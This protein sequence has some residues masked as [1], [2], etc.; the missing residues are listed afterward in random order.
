MQKTQKQSGRMYSHTSEAEKRTEEVKVRFNLSE[1]KTVQENAARSGKLPS[2][3]CREVALGKEQVE[4]KNI[5]RWGNLGRLG[6]EFLETK[7]M[8]QQRPETLEHLMELLEEAV[9]EI[10]ALRRELT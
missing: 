7:R 6:K 3:Y 9:Q 4:V 5:E 2:V 1:L 10:K 8:L